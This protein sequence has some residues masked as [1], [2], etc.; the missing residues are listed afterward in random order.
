MKITDRTDST[1]TLTD[2]QADKA[3]A[4]YGL[5]LILAG[6]AMMMAW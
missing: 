2:T 3:I 1:L 4:L 6:F 5:A